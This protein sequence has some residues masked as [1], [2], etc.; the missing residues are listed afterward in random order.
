M[1]RDEAEERLDGWKGALR[2][3]RSHH[4][5]DARSEAPSTP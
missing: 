4:D 3:A 1:P 5:D 2:L